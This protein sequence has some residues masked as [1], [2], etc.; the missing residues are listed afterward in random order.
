MTINLAAIYHEGKSKFAYAY[1]KETVH[2]RLRTAKNDLD[3]VKIIYGDP[4]NWGPKKDKNNSDDTNA[5]E[6]K[7]ENNKELL[8]KKEYSTHLH[9][10]W[11]I[12][13]KPK[14]RR[15]KYCFILEKDNEKLLYG[16]K[17]IEDLTIYP[18]KEKDLFNYFNFPFINPIDIFKAPAW[19]KETIWYQI[20]PERFN[21]G[22]KDNDP[23]NTLEW[24]SIEK[25]R[26][27]MFFGGD[28]EG[29]IDKLDYIQ[30][31]GATGIYF[32]PIFKSPSTHKYDTEDYFQIDP[33]FG[34]LDTMKRLVKEAH[35][36]G[37]KV[38]LDAVFNHCGW[39]H[40]FFQDVLENGENSPYKDYFHI[41]K[42]PLFEGNPRDFKFDEE[43]NPL[44]YDTFA[45]TPLMPKWNTENE[46]LK[47]Y[48][49]QAATY[50]IKECDIDAWRLDVSNEVD[51]SFWRDFR[52]ACDN[53]KKDF[54]IV[55]E[56]WDESN[57]WIQPDQMQSV[58]NYDFLF[59]V[60]NFFGANNGSS[61]NFKNDINRL[62]T[63]YPKHVGAYLFNLLD[64]HDS[65]RILTI[66]QGNKEKVK[67]AYVFQQTFGGTPS[68]YYGG[69]ISLAGGH[70]PDNRRCMIWGE[71]KQDLD[72]FKHLQKLI[73][74][75]KTH[76]AL[77]E[78]DL[79]WLDVN[80]DNN[81]IVYKK[82]S[83]E[84][85]IYVI[86]NN[87]DSTTTLA[88]DELIG[89]KCVDLYSDTT[90]TINNPIKVDNYGFLILK[91]LNQ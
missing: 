72:M 90:K 65:T 77:R 53:E 11:F 78:V 20:F 3:N 74:L 67:L 86:I 12:P 91:I 2:I 69:E 32:T 14:Y 37:I 38:M 18:E 60:W 46:A 19:A 6:W 54:F 79:T 55:G 81:Q 26:N 30:E 62:L 51:H 27:E 59:S 40:P 52:K 88:I 58:M 48:L 57:P 21:N 64:S 44:N 34:N 42:F 13:I 15:T 36:R 22:N 1:D 50:W 89:K 76:P 71:N 39:N 85:T 24:G 68:I 4:F 70:D 23:A 7:N 83:T 31:L 82:E 41:K 45:F 9:D 73:Q 35:K 63:T 8:M 47:D 16:A 33:Q 66:C 75:R 25:V 10:F 80:S 29:V 5:Y 17:S 28:L 87:E 61:E 56:N 49:L 43:K 84:E